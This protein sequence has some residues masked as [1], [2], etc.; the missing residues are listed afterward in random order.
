MSVLFVK[1]PG[2]DLCLPFPTER[3]EAFDTGCPIDNGKPTFFFFFNTSLGC[4]CNLQ[5]KKIPEV[6]LVLKRP[7]LVEGSGVMSINGSVL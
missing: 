5:N 7:S 6:S 2:D 1:H 4:H 3:P